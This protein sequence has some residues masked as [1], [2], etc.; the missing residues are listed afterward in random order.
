MALMLLK[1]GGK[2]LAKGWENIMIYVQDPVCEELI[3]WEDARR[4]IRF[5]GQL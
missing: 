2:A 1:K 4:I 5:D 3:A